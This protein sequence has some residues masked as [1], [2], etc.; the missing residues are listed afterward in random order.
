MHRL[1]FGLVVTLLLVVTSLPAAAAPSTRLYLA[2]NDGL[3]Q[4]W[5]TDPGDGELGVTTARWRC[6]PGLATQRSCAG[7]STSRF[8][9]VFE[10]A[11]LLD[12]PVQ[13]TA[14]NPVRFHF[15]MD[16][17][18]AEPF[19]IHAAFLDGLQFATSAP[20][21]QVSPGVWEGVITER[22]RWNPNARGSLIYLFVRGP[23]GSVPVDIDLALGGRSYIELPGAVPARAVPELTRTSPD[24][25]QPLT[26]T[27][28]ARSFWFN[29]AQ[30]E[31]TTFEGDLSAPRAF[32]VSLSRPAETVYAWVEAFEGPLVHHAA[33]HGEVD[34]ARFTDA[35]IISLKRN[36]A[37]IAAGPAQYNQRGRGS[38]ALATT[39]VPAGT[40]TLDVKQYDNVPAQ[41]Q[42]YRAYVL[43]IYGDR[44]LQR[45][46]WRYEPSI[47]EPF[48]PARAGLGTCVNPSEPVPTTAAV[49]TFSVDVDWDTVGMPNAQYTVGYEPS[50]CGERGIGDRVRFT[51][52][53]AR[54]W[55]FAATPSRS[56]TFAGYRDTVF[57]MDVRYSYAPRA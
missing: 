13:W 33:R 47:A 51:T 38:N 5:T 50:Y 53:G 1:L 8:Y 26:Y 37:E 40:V 41:G 24:A 3:Y 39:R 16:V 14:D 46:R 28:P 48:I 27:T 31:V 45:M 52:T 4:Y 12:G 9:T 22:G 6:G 43:A 10:P 20:A 21:V 34:V 54:V 29:D 57:E 30:W 15:E 44:T 32:D 19:T 36:G 11:A 56:A 23:Q 25:V 35:P 2:S 49:T 17:E 7:S 42:A 55:T 18:S